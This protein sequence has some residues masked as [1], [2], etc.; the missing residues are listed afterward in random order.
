MRYQDDKLVV[1]RRESET[2]GWGQVAGL[3]ERE[4]MTIDKAANPNQ[5]LTRQRI[6]H[7]VPPFIIL[8]VVFS[9]FAVVIFGG[10]FVFLYDDTWTG[11]DSKNGSDCTRYHSY[12]M[13]IT[14][15]WDR[16]LGSGLWSVVSVSIWE[17]GPDPV[18]CLTLRQ[19]P[20]SDSYAKRKVPPHWVFLIFKA[21]S[22]L[23]NY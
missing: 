7:G 8:F 22:I 14:C 13:G 12:G 1:N 16:G 20:I 17:Y 4:Q 9:L 2:E 6:Y 3:S 18:Q 15:W 10:N 5:P 11:E 23:L 21:T 19:C